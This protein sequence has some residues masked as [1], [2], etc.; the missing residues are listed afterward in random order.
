MKMQRRH[1]LAALALLP[2]LP[3]AAHAARTELNLGIYPG[4]GKADVL[5]G[6]FRAWAMPFAQALGAAMGAKPGLTL[7]RSIKSIARSME[8]GRLDMYLVPPSVAV[9]A[10]DHRYSPVARVRDQATGV[11]VRRKG[12]AVTTVALTE[13]ESWLD[14]MARHTLR[15]N[16]QDAAQILN[17]KTQE[18]VVLAMQR[19]F[20]QAGSL[21]SKLA[22]ELV[23]RGEFETWY[24]LPAT[25]DFTLMASNR[26]SAAEQDKLG[27]AAAALSPEVIQSL[28]KTIHSKVTGFVID[29]QADYQLI[30]QAIREAGY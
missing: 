18:E 11:L 22:D 5:M 21:R 24:A 7:F 14:V 15:R 29:K 20:A 1:F 2:V 23:A 27:S 19:D 26:F 16:R 6:D 17:L 25:P 8:G 30:K 28:Q 13:K 12:A 9:A 3:L 10:L 4:T